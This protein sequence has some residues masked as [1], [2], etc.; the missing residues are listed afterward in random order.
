MLKPIVNRLKER[1]KPHKLV[2]IAVL[3]AGSSSSRTPF[4]KRLLHIG[5][6]LPHRYCCWRRGSGGG[7]RKYA[8]THAPLSFDQGGSAKCSLFL[9]MGIG[10]WGVGGKRVDGRV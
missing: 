3:Q 4:S 8:R 1:G 7:A 9:L 10:K 2:I 6:A 5:R